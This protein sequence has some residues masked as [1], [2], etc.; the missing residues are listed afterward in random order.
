MR[1]CPETVCFQGNILLSYFSNLIDVASHDLYKLPDVEIVFLF[2]ILTTGYTAILYNFLRILLSRFSLPNDSYFGV[3]IIGT[4][5]SLNAVLL[6]FTLVQAINTNAKAKTLVLNELSSIE[7]FG[8]KLEF[9]PESDA[10]TIRSD[11]IIY[12]EAVADSGWDMMISG[13][14]N[15]ITERAFSTLIKT[16]PH[17]RDNKEIDRDFLKEFFISFNDLVKSRYDRLK[18][19]GTRLPY[20]YL[21]AVLFLFSMHI[22]QFFLL[23]KINNYSLLI[24]QL[25]MASLGLLLGLVFVYDHPFEGETS[26]KSS[27]YRDLVTKIKDMD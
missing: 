17:L 18:M 5:T 19:G 15:P 1:Y 22:V 6:I 12:L 26:I 25:H 11:L 9:I 16:I 8:R 2:V 4:L 24:L 27:V 14:Q 13:K 7:L 23:A 21:L 10:K 20:Y 3:T